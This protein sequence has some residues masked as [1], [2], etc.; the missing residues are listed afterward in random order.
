MLFLQLL[1]MILIPTTDKRLDE[2][3]MPRLNPKR[4]KVGDTIMSDG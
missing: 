3:N 2:E 4:Q 1:W